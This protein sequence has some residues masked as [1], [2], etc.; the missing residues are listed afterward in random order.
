M[1]T[2]LS[3]YVLIFTLLI[4]GM[5]PLSAIDVKAETAG[6]IFT[7]AGLPEGYVKE[8]GTFFT[9]DIKDGENNFIDYKI[10]SDEIE[11]D[12]YL[13]TLSLNDGY[14]YTISGEFK[15][16]NESK[17]PGVYFHKETYASEAITALVNEKTF[18]FNNNTIILNLEHNGFNFSDRWD[19]EISNLDKDETYSTRYTYAFVEPGNYLIALDGETPE[20]EFIKAIKEGEFLS[21]TSIVFDNSAIE[22]MEITFANLDDSVRLSGVYSLENNYFSMH[23]DITRILV[24]DPVS[25]RGTLETETYEYDFIIPQLETSKTI[26][27]STDF[28]VTIE[29]ALNRAEISVTNGDIYIADSFFNSS[30]SP[31]FYEFFNDKGELVKSDQKDSIGDISYFG[32]E[33][34]E[35]T[36]K[37]K[38]QLNGSEITE[39]K[40]ITVEPN[41]W[42]FM[43]TDNYVYSNNSMVVSGFYGPNQTVSADLYDANLELIETKQETLTTEVFNIRFSNLLNGQYFVQVRAGSQ[44]TELIPFT[45]NKS[46]TAEPEPDQDRGTDESDQENSTTPTLDSTPVPETGKE[47]LIKFTDV[48]DRY[49]E[50]VSYLVKNQITVGFADN[51]FGT[52]QSIKR[53]DAAIMMAKALGLDTGNASDAGF[54]DVPE[55]GK[56]A[57][58]ALANAGITFGKAEGYFGAK[59]YITRAEMTAFIARGFG[60]ESTNEKVIPFSD[61]NSRFNPFVSALYEHEI[62][63]G[64]D[65][66][67]F[68]S[69]LEVTRGEFALFLFRAAIQ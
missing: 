13:S 10:L 7:L 9:I 59:E 27:L 33:Y 62:T 42:L 15:I 25:I 60:F 19:F 66:D 69:N 32:L 17:E 52:D 22:F 14:S 36:L 12:N 37:V 63:F 26:S 45:V 53:V 39:E 16:L 40:S 58:N 5:Y 29:S 68:G 24:S 49:K 35:Y 28:Y 18:I 54:T 44:Q 56:A 23:N 48:N 43:P 57:V 20:K 4:G 47:G 11:L 55:R 51:K 3:K 6:S 8:S 30:N 1:L 41:L 65:E 61:V 31:M 21:D 67:T 50:A 64:K 34:G 2:V 46:E 38:V